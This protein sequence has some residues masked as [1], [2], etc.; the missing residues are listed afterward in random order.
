MLKK[1]KKE[2][3]QGF[4]IIEVMIVLAIA[5]LILLIVFLAIP[6][7]QRSSR[8][9][10]RKEDVGRIGTAVQTIISNNNGSISALTTANL[11]NEVGDNQLSYYTTPSSEVSVVAGPATVKNGSSIT[12]VIVY[13]AA[14]CAAMTGGQGATTTGA[15]PTNVAIA[16]STETGGTPDKVCVSQ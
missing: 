4:T 14:V 1:S 13:T 10:Q 3:N 8:N 12:T 2:A 9:T 15:Q 16:Y 6:A 7:L 5:A 11:D